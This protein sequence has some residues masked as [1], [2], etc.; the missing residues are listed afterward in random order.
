MPCRSLV[1]TA[2]AFGPLAHGAAGQPL[3][4]RAPS[5][6]LTGIVRDSMTGGAVGYALVTLVEGNQ[7]VFASE[8]GR[9]TL[10][11]LQS[12]RATLRV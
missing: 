1:L 11:G 9:F 12:G 5:G 2:L 10:S 6:T 8:G 4:V 7:R 3:R